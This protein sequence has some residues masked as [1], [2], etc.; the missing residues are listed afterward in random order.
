MKLFKMGPEPTPQK[1]YEMQ[2]RIRRSDK[3]MIPI[4]IGGAV[5]SVINVHKYASKGDGGNAVWAAVAVLAFGLIIGQIIAQRALM[6]AL[7]N[8]RKKNVKKDI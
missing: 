2:Q 4:F 8:I 1:Q 7:S 3:Y 6:K 5:I